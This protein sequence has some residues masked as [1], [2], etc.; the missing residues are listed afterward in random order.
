MKHAPALTALLLIA[1][2]P[3]VHAQFAPTPDASQDGTSSDNGFTRPGAQPGTTAP[4]PGAGT[5]PVSGRAAPPAPDVSIVPSTDDADGDALQ[6]AYADVKAGRLD[7]AAAK[8]AD[9]V[10]KSPGN[11]SA[12]SMLGYVL[13]RQNKGADAVREME[14]VV[15]LVPANAGAHKNLAQAYLQ[16]GQFDRAAAQFRTVLTKT[17]KDSGALSGLALALGQAGRSDEAAAAFQNLLAVAPSAQGYQNLGVTLNKAGKTAPAAAAFRKAAELSPKDD[18]SWLNAGLLY[19]KAGQNTDAV[20]A[21]THALATGGPNKFDALIT[22]GQIYG[23]LKQNDKAMA[24]FAAASSLRPAEVLPL[25]NLAVLQQ[26]AGQKADAEANFRKVLALKPSDPQILAGAQSS[27]GLLLA[28]ESNAAE[29]VPLLEQAAQSDPQNASLHSALASLYAKQGEMAKAADERRTVLTL[30]P[31]D[32]SNRLVLA[33]MLAAQKDNAG[34]LALYRD[35]ARREPGNASIQNALGT[36]YV[37]ARNL[38]AALLA[39]QAALAA[40][41]KNAL[42]ANNVGVVYDRQGKR[43]Q[44]IAAFKKALLLDPTLRDA[45]VNLSRYGVKPTAAH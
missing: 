35:A 43:T 41:P 16:T 39:F 12:H 23:S 10:K 8:L 3:A 15:K 34:A 20:D 2:A 26:N 13:L 22:R 27:L 36:A 31:D 11:P 14:T 28:S 21:L 7:A 4:T 1:L 38:D 6:K 40:D 19:A 5:N 17:P 24:D 9:I 30:A 29:A 25:F 42:A 45:R 32:N 37:Q 33:D 18:V 44:A